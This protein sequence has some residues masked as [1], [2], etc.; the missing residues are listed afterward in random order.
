MKTNRL[1]L[2]N[3][4][5]KTKW[6]VKRYFANREVNH[7]DSCLFEKAVTLECTQSQAMMIPENVRWNLYREQAI[8]VES[9]NFPFKEMT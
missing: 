9:N 8:I 2:F 1:N 4:D 6:R 7:Y 3:Q 5:L